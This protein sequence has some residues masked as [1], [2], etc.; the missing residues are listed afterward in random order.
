MDDTALLG[1]VA[2][3]DVASLRELY[4]RHAPVLAVRLRRRCAD[5]DAVEDA[6]QDTSWPRGRRRAAS[7]A[8]AEVAAWLWGIPLRSTAGPHLSGTCGIIVA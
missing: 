7:A 4:D 6:L 2:E 1:A 5:P 8:T 3:G